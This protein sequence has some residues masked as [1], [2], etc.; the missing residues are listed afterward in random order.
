MITK[1]PP[2]AI[3]IPLLTHILPPFSYI[4]VHFPLPI[5]T[6]WRFRTFIMHERRKLVS[7]RWYIL[8]QCNVST[9]AEQGF[10]GRGGDG[11]KRWEDGW[12]EYV[13]KHLCHHMINYNTTPDWDKD[14]NAYY[15]GTGCRS[16]FGGMFKKSLALC[17]TLDTSIP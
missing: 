4:D 5:L 1:D 16:Y 13:E 17:A 9:S 15:R 12:C 14:V 6:S 7:R 3:T 10:R 11:N 8:R 2:P